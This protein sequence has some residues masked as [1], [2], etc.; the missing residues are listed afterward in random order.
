MA[1]PS[2]TAPAPPVAQGDGVVK[3]CG[4]TTALSGAS[5]SIGHGVTGLLGAN[6]AGKTT[7]LGLMLG[8]HRPDAGN[9]AVLGLDPATAGPEVRARVGYAPEHHRL[10]PDVKAHDLVRH[11]AEVHGLP[12]REATAR[13]SDALWQVGLGE[14]R[15]RPVGT[16][17]TGQR[18]RVKLA[19]GDRP[20]PRAGAARRAHR[21]ARPGAARRR[22][23]RSSAAS[24]DEFGIDVV[25]SSHLLD[26]VE[27]ICDAAVILSE[28]RVVAGGTLDELRGGSRGL[29]VEVTDGG[30]GVAV[31]AAA[32]GL[33]GEPGRRPAHRD[34]G[35]APP[36][37]HDLRRPGAAMPSSPP[38]APSLADG[39]PPLTVSLEDVFLD[40]ASMTAARRRPHPRPRLPPLRRRPHRGDAAPCAASRRTP[41]SG[42][43]ACAAPRRSKILPVLAA[44][45]AYV[46]AIVFVG[47]AALLPRTT[48]LENDLLPTYAEYYGFI[49]SAIVVFVAFVAPE[50]L[51]T[52]R[53]T[54]ML[55][56]Y[57]A[58]P[59]TRYTYLAGQGPVGHG[60]PRHR[61]PRPAA[62]PAHRLRAARHR[63]RRPG[64][65]AAVLRAHRGRR[66]A[67]LGV[68]RVVVD[69]R[70]QPHRPARRRPRRPSW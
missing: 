9:L 26:E 36:P 8:L 64:R 46:P 38:Q 62:V 43:S 10:P 3:R 39:S 50:V 17:S 19:A 48:F 56:L 52:D 28:G 44:L 49:T 69:G 4:A 51:C 47:L 24:A 25:L 21:R 40:L 15:F 23:S 67:G 16:M 60:R 22:C 34:A 41:P 66:R 53:R 14:E 32:G 61:H 5:F 13:A 33:R 2:S 37:T 20:R 58:S 59:L 70:V 1:A 45:L 54:G 7:L 29:V 12:R 35:R 65:R 30:D 42:P 31:L 55:G 27:R 63:A 11:L 18:Q 57:L 6:G 68:L